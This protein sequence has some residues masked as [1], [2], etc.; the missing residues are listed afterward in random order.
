MIGN[1]IDDKITKVSKNLPQNNS[2]TVESEIENT[3][4]DKEVP[5]ERYTSP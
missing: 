2:K 5:K 4:F 3:G 1:K